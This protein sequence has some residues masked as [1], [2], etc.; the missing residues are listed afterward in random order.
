MR[1]QVYTEP[2]SRTATLWFAPACAA[3]T[4]AA[5][6]PPPNVTSLSTGGAP[7]TGP[8]PRWPS[9]EQPIEYSLP[10]F[11]TTSVWQYPPST[12]RTSMP[13]S[14]VTSVARKRFALPPHAPHCL[15]WFSPAQKT[16]PSRAMAKVL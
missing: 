14:S 12:A 4:A 3:L 15:F 5:A 2:S 13:L 11:E 10:P 7:P 9:S 6:P 16:L 8:M 1:P